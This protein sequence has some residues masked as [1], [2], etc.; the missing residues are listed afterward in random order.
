MRREIIA[1]LTTF[2]R[3]PRKNVKTNTRKTGIAP[4]QAPRVPE[5]IIASKINTVALPTIARR[6]F[7]TKNVIAIG[8]AKIIESAKECESG[9]NENIRRVASASS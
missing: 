2:L 8:K 9:K 4:I 5:K 1:I 6:H 3:G 7:I